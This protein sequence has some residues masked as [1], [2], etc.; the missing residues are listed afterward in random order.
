MK[1]DYEKIRNIILEQ[2]PFMLHELISTAKENGIT[3]RNIIFAALNDLFDEGLIVYRRTENVTVDSINQNFRYQVS[4]PDE[5]MWIKQRIISKSGNHIDMIV[6][7]DCREEYSYDAE[8]GIKMDN[9]SFCPNC[10][11]KIRS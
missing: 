11:I 9:Y 7:P 5:K 3:D 4:V 2:K 1:S 6:C 10:G 8:T